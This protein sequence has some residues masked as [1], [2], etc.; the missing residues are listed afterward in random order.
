MIKYE[1]GKD[2]EKKSQIILKEED[3]LIKS[4]NLKID[5]FAKLRRKNN[6]LNTF[7]PL[8]THL[9]YKV[10]FKFMKQFLCK[11]KFLTKK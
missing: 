3:K 6:Y 4:I 7:N 5:N 1:Y 11:I 9:Y 2:L 10:S 8:T